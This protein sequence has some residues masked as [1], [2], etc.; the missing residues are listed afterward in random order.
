MNKLSD[1]LSIQFVIAN[2]ARR[3]TFHGISEPAEIAPN[4]YVGVNKFGQVSMVASPQGYGA[5]MVASENNNWTVHRI[6]K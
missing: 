1:A 3:C 4:M 6:S 2:I 5:L